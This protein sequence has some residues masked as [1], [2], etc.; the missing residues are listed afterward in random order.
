MEMIEY[1]NSLDNKHWTAGVNKRFEGLPIG[2]VKDLCGV[3][4]ESERVVR[5]NAIPVYG[6]TNT[7]VQ[8]PESFD[9]MENWPVG[10]LTS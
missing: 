6:R 5:E 4:P 3:K 2:S 7:D 1:I 9:S 10:V 8:I